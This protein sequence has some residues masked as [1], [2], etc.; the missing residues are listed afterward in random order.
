[1]DGIIYKYTS[2]SGKNYIG[3]TIQGELRKDQH[4]RNAHNKNYSGYFLPFY[5]AIRKYGF[6]S[7]EYEV[8]ITICKDGELELIE[9]LNK[10]EI[11]YIGKYNS[12]D[13][14]YNISL[15]GS[16]LNSFDHPSRKE[17][18]Q[19]DKQG[20]FIASFDSGAQAALSVGLKS[21]SSLLKCCRLEGTLSKG[22]QWRFIKNGEIILKIEPAKKRKS[23]SKTY[24][25]KNNKQ[26]KTVYQYDLDNN[27]IKKW[28]S[29]MDITRELGYDSGGISRVC[30]GKAPYYGK[31]GC[32][33]FIWSYAKLHNV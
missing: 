29:L 25:G 30:N 4:R 33:K 32:E 22:F 16:G 10:L 27:F 26:S 17:V 21:S 3:Q 6:D 11:Y 23:P 12:V 20:N 14:G 15:G 13:F 8:L 5:C 31:R 24:L 28:D 2:P 19:Y 1:M 7:L 9:E 18:A